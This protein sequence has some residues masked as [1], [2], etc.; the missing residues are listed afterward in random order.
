M[1][2]SGNP[3]GYTRAFFLKGSDMGRFTIVALLV[4][5]AAAMAAERVVLFEEFTQTG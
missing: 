4:I 3:S 1:Y 5:A 2:V